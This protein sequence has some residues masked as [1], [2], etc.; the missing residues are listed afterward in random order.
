MAATIDTRGYKYTPRNPRQSEVMQAWSTTRLFFLTGEG[1]TGK[2]DVAVG[3]A[4]ADLFAKDASRPVRQIYLSRPTVACDEEYGFLEGS[5]EEKYAPWMNAFSSV[6]KRTGHTLQTLS[7]VMIP[8]PLGFARGDTIENAIWIVDEAQNCT[9]KQLR[10]IGSRLGRNAKIILAGDD[11]QV[12]LPGRGPCPLFRFA[13][14][15]EPD[16]EVS[17]IRFLPEDQCR[18]PFVTR[19]LKLTRDL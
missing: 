12:D 9:A 1:G 2:T 11:D 18:D 10:M 13:K 16:P 7:K 5:I 4:M 8:K 19:F 3:M 14:V 15:M 6:M 17:W